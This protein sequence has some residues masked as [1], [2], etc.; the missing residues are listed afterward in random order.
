MNDFGPHFK[1]FLCRIYA[2]FVILKIV[3]DGLYNFYHIGTDSACKIFN[4]HIHIK[5]FG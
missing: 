2:F 1:I 4:E 3:Y 5:Y